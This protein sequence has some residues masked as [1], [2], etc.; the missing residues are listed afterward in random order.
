MARNSYN[1]ISFCPVIS[2]STEL[3][4][5]ITRV[6]KKNDE[7]WDDPPYFL[8]TFVGANNLLEVPTMSVCCLIFYHLNHCRTCQWKVV[9]IS[10]I[11]PIGHG[12]FSLLGLIAR[13][14]RITVYQSLFHLEF[15]SMIFHLTIFISST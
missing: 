5:M 12:D 2:R 15:R 11:F 8:H 9:T 3:G 13:G 4:L 7:R 6:S 14:F 1:H 10:T